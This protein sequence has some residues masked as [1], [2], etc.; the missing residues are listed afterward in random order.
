VIHYALPRY[1]NKIWIHFD[2]LMLLPLF[3][4]GLSKPDR[5]KAVS[6][7]FF[8]ENLILPP[9][10]LK[11]FED[12]VSKRPELAVGRFTTPGFYEL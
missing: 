3:G 12:A 8:S 10:L 7:T 11:I 6:G 2:D 1:P 4:A 9:G 5:A